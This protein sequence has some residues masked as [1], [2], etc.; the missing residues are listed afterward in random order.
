MDGFGEEERLGDR[1]APRKEALEGDALARGA[2]IEGDD[3]AVGFEKQVACS[4]L[5]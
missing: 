4:G 3:A 1:G 2:R 5:G